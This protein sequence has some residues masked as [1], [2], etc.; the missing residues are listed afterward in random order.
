MVLPTNY[1]DQIKK[2][3]G[4]HQKPY[5]DYKQWTSGYGTR[6]AG[7]DDVVDPAE[8]ER[9]LNAEIAKAAEL[10]DNFA[11]GLD[12]GTRAALTSLT[13]NAGGDWMTSGLGQAIKAG[14]LDSARASFQQYTKAGGQTLPGLVNRRQAE[15][16]W[17]G[18][19]GQDPR[20]VAMN[21]GSA[22]VLPT[23]FAGVSGAAQTDNPTPPP[24]TAPA[25]N[26]AP[27]PSYGLLADALGTDAKQEGSFLGGLLGGLGKAAQFE[28]PQPAQMQ[29]STPEMRGPNADL[30]RLTQ[31]VRQRRL[32]ARGTA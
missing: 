20:N 3:E 23:G 1:L 28:A 7:P 9:R 10:V 17:F 8:A 32:G 13:F 29:L 19:A 11:P 27:A 25:Q 4:F 5:W 22:G 26:A 15:L 12:A 18:Q 24:N 16:A 6:A 2:F 30:S 31:A 14:D 21:S